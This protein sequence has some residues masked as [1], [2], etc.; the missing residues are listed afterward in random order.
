MKRPLT[1][2]IATFCYRGTRVIGVFQSIKG[3]QS[4]C[5]EEAKMV[6]GANWQELTKWDGYGDNRMLNFDYYTFDVTPVQVQ[7]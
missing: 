7:A 6:V 2:Y 1:V 3:A 5:E 4:A